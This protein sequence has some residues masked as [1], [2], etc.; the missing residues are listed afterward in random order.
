MVNCI[1]EHYY[2]DRISKPSVIKIDPLFLIQNLVRGAVAKLV[3][4][5]KPVVAL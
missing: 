4:R 2:I 5:I 3:M 1:Q